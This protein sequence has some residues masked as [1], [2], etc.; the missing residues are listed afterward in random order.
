MRKFHLG[1]ALALLAA[2]CSS[3]ESDTGSSG[4]EDTESSFQTNQA[5]RR[6]AREAA[7]SAAAPE[8]SAADA[9]CDA[10]H[11]TFSSGVFGTYGRTV[12]AAIMTDHPNADSRLIPHMRDNQ[13]MRFKFYADQNGECRV[14]YYGSDTF[15]GTNYR[16][17]G[18]CALKLDSTPGPDGRP[19]YFGTNCV[20]E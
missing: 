19:D 12:A 5:G 18:N 11:E 6:A 8:I 13:S 16:L 14:R 7:A 20:S 15:N 4:G 2:A 10:K 17:A 9:R 1:G 3:G